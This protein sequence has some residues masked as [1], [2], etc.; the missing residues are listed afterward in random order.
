MKKKFPC[1]HAGKGSYCHQCAQDKQR[2]E[3]EQQ[4]HEAKQA[5]TA[6]RGEEFARDLVDLQGMPQVVID[7]ARLII[8]D[9]QAG[10]NWIE[11]GGVKFNARQEIVRF[12]LPRQ[13][14]LVCE[15]TPDGIM[16]R[17]VMTH[18]AYNKWL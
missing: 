5:R 4:V 7:K 8:A 9:L 16:P 13:Y 3:A 12:K 11:L 10:A 18:E 15:F 14:R 17:A 6:A 1:G 2:K